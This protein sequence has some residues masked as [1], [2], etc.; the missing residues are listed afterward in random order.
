MKKFFTAFLCCILILE[1]LPQA[2]F[3]A[4]EAL[5]EGLSLQ[6]EYDDR[7]CIDDFM[8]GYRVVS[9]SDENV[10]SFKVEGG[11]VTDTLDDAVISLN[12]SSSE[13]I[14]CGCGSAVMVIAPEGS[15]NDESTWVTVNVTVS[16]AQLALIFLAGQSNMEGLCSADTGYELSQSV[17]CPEGEVYS[18]YAPTIKSVSAYVTGVTFSEMCTAENAADFVAG[19]LSSQTSLSGNELEY[20][21]DS[22][23]VSGSGKTGPDSAIAYKWNELTGEKVWIVNAAVAGTSI[24][25]WQK[26][27]TRYERAAAVFSCVLETYEAEIAAGHYSAGSRL[28]FWMQGEN[29]R[30]W[31]AS[32]YT[33]YFT[34]MC[35]D[36]MADFALDAIGMISIRSCMYSNTDDD[37]LY[38]T[39]PR[40]AQYAVGQSADYEN[41]FV[42]SNANESWTSD[43]GVADYF[44]QNYPQGY[45]DYPLRDTAKYTDS[46]P[47]S[48]SEIHTGLHYS[49]TGH[50]ENGLTAAQGMY[51]ALF[52]SGIAE[53]VEWKDEF[54]NSISSIY[55]CIDETAAVV[56]V[57]EPVYYGKTVTYTVSNSKIEY[58]ASSGTITGVSSGTAYIYAYADGQLVSQLKVTVVSSSYRTG[59]YYISSGTFAYYKNGV[60][61]TSFTGM[62]YYNDIWYYV[63]EGYVYLNFNGVILY[64]GGAWYISRG[65]N[66]IS[67][68]G[69]AQTEDGVTYYI[70]NGYSALD[71]TGLLTIDGSTYCVT[72]S[73]VSTGSGLV[74]CDGTWYYIY[75][76]TVAFDYT[77]LAVYSGVFW[78]V[79][80]GAVDFSYCGLFDFEGDTYYIYAGRVVSASGLY[81]VDGT[82]YL[83]EDGVIAS[84]FTGLVS[85]NGYLWLVEGG[86]VNLSYCGLFDFEG[87]TY[88]I[89]AGR[90]VSASGLYKVDGTWYLFEDGVIASGFTGLVSYNGYLWLVE[91]GSVNFSYYGL[92]DFEGDTYYIYA[93]R[94]IAASG[95]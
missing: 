29:D 10:T 88:Y 32:L 25:S 12:G 5:D 4:A 13:I 30:S 91:G 53:D 47:E 55:I 63:D 82:W 40:I 36:F 34:A 75:E 73:E 18:T 24:T 31:S 26:G 83:F 87:D 21:T 66:D 58:D 78:Y 72:D 89:Y 69:L 48:V 76:D 20:P 68:T 86:S 92:F 7:L 46:L 84:G 28:L 67:Y 8:E 14:A 15:E 33:E 44:A 23:T 17:A 94:V 64:N 39:G 50:N 16:S 1:L 6:L 45:L 70:E 3:K 35:A 41:I 59:I 11:A 19:S 22:L 71:Y 38:M 95:S 62:I 74:Y 42:V 81:K 9:I 51:E 57:A 61:Y 79:E 49:Q 65:V 56:A 2:A 54:G 52:G 77:G 85:Y 93:G 43:E 60:I 90:V 27:E 37:D 80:N